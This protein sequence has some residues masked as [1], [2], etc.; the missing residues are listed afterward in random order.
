[1]LAEL[2][3]KKDKQTITKEGTL[4]K[5]RIEGVEIRYLTPIEDERGEVME[6]FNPSWGFHPDAFVYLYQVRIRP[7]KVKGWVVHRE[8]DDRIFICSG[9]ARIVLYDYREN[10]PTYKMLND[11]VISERRP[12]IIIFP[13][14]VF[15]AIQNIGEKEVIFFNM[16]TKAYNYENPDKYRLPINNDII[17]FDFEDSLGW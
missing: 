14:G 15:H 7:G 16:P 8:Q 10:S 11:L 5:S 13:K 9:T 3:L 17:P 2:P 1:M 4:K 12:A 6:V